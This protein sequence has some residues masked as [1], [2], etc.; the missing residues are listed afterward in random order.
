MEIVSRNKIYFVEADHDKTVLVAINLR[1]EGDFVVWFDTVK[2]RM[3]RCKQIVENTEGAL[4]FERDDGDGGVY[5]FVPLTLDIY[6]TVVKKR[7]IS[8][9]DFPDEQTM[10][11]AFLETKRGAW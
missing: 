4:A 1:L 8:G 7:L 10:Y 3:M 5:R 2:E 6:N 9:G 11:E